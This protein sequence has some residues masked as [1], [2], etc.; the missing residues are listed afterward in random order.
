MLVTVGG[1]EQFQV[2]P[3]PADKLDRDRKIVRGVTTGHDDARQA[4]SRGEIV[5]SFAR[6]VFVFGRVP[7]RRWD[8]L[9]RKH[10][11]IQVQTFDLF[12]HPPGRSAVRPTLPVWPVPDR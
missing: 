7:R 2:A 9:V 8:G 1:L 4:R 6:G 11:G 10:H 3:R 12:A 5:G